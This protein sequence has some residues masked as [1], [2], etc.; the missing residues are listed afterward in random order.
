MNSEHS[1]NI[2]WTKNRSEWNKTEQTPLVFSSLPSNNS[3]AQNKSRSCHYSN[4]PDYILALLL[5]A[6]APLVTRPLCTYWILPTGRHHSSLCNC[7]MQKWK[8]FHAKTAKKM[9]LVG[10]P[11]FQI[12][13]GFFV[14]EC[15]SVSGRTPLQC[16][17]Y[18]IAP[19]GLCRDTKILV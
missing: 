6:V 4:I 13:Q 12:K 16:T 3:R 2:Q 5:W 17:M 1:V 8:T 7:K 11:G 19:V 14:S 15:V 10:R 9:V 18:W